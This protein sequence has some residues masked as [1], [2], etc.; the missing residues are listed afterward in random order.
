MS[1]LFE[2]DLSDRAQTELIENIDEQAGLDSVPRE[3]RNALQYFSAATIFAR[4]RLDYTRKF[5]EKQIQKWSGSDLRHPSPSLS[6]VPVNRREGAA[7]ETF[8]V[9]NSGIPEKGA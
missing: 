4:E 9:L 3:E 5:R 7:V 6:I 1:T 8:N 2:I